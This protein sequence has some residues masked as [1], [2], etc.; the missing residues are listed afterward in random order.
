VAATPGKNF[1][2]CLISCTTQQ[3]FIH[4]RDITSTVF[5]CPMTQ[6]DMSII[7]MVYDYEGCGVEHIRKVFFKDQASGVSPA[8]DGLTI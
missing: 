1:L 3:V 5:I 6:R 8:T 2:F 7:W 4:S